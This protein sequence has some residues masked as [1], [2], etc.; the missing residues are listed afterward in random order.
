MVT[1]SI[2]AFV[3]HDLTLAHAVIEYDDVVDDL[4][5]RVKD[6]LIELIRRDSEKGEYA[7]DMLMIAKYFERIGTTLLI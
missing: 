2:D 3:R 4:F 6:E 5:N 7:V 1:D